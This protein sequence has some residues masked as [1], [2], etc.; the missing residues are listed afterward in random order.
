M[1]IEVE[2]VASF[3]QLFSYI[4]LDCRTER[5]ILQAGTG[6]QMFVTDEIVVS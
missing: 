4:T 5:I 1:S 6:M 3:S 2:I